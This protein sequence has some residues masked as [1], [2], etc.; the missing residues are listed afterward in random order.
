LFSF[1]VKGVASSSGVV[2]KSSPWFS[3][4]ANATRTE[5]YEL[6]QF[7]GLYICREH[8]G[9]RCLGTVVDYDLENNK[10]IVWFSLVYHST[11][12]L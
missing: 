4:R 1:I 7:M 8:N 6:Y 9:R 10:L 12:F 3:N 11:Y 5:P 2:K